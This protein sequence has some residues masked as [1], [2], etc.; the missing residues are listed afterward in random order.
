M[1]ITEAMKL[2][3]AAKVRR[4]QAAVVNGR[5]FSENLIKAP[6]G[7]AGSGG[8]RGGAI[9]AAVIFVLYGV[10]QRLRVEDVDSPLCDIRPVKSVLLVVLSGDRGLCGGYNNFIIKKTEAR[11]RELKALGLDV[12]LV[13]V[14]R[15]AQQYFGRRPQY[16]VVR[17]FTLGA[18]PTT[19][20]AQAVADEIFADFVSKEVDKVELVY[21]KFLSLIASNPTIQT[22]LPL[23]PTGELCDVE[24]NC[25]D[26]AQDEMFRLTTSGGKLS[27]EREKVGG[28]CCEHAR[29]WRCPPPSWT[30]G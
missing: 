5:P 12:K 11:H 30:P 2:V 10:N 7:Q 29:A 20:E 26:A 23:T 6:Q 24:G 27:V 13:L 25:V 14:G 28:G 16:N 22:L 17:N 4:A 21:T 9:A 18:A 3:A 8:A 19:R 1:K 15:K